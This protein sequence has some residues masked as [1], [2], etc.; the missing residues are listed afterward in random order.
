MSII[1]Y[2]RLTG[3][4]H[5]DTLRRSLGEILLGLAGANNVNQSDLATVLHTT[6]PRISDLMKGHY[7]KF[8]SDWLF[9]RISMIGYVPL[10]SYD[11]NKG[12]QGGE[13][14]IQLRN[15]GEQFS[16]PDSEFPCES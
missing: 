9:E 3:E 1:T 10:I 13:L 11:T 8:S 5:R 6:Q 4:K 16:L 7:E 12:W 14:A 15:M 2:D